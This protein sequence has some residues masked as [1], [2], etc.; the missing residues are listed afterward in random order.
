MRDY[1]AIRNDPAGALSAGKPEK[2]FTGKF[3]QYASLASIFEPDTPVE[4]RMKATDADRLYLHLEIPSDV[5]KYSV[6][7]RF[8]LSYDA[9]KGFVTDLAGNRMKSAHRL[10]SRLQ[11]RL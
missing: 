1:F 8:A 11:L 10:I 7:Q 2:A 3:G 5:E 4:K 9:D 6:S